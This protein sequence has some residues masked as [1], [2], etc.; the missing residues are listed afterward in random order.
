M[1]AECRVPTPSLLLSHTI[2]MLHPT[3][4]TTTHK[5]RTMAQPAPSSGLLQSSSDHGTHYRYRSCLHTP[6]PTGTRTSTPAGAASLSLSDHD[7]MHSNCSSSSTRSS[8]GSGSRTGR[9]VSFTHVDIVELSVELGHHPSCRTGPPLQLGRSVA[10]ERQRVPFQEFEQE[11][12]PHRRSL[13][14]LY[15]S[16]EDRKK[17]L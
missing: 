15:L 9:K 3:T 7:T 11:R 2:I 4:I 6:S 17:L 8:S 13:P 5:A 12:S 14:Q 16:S 10:Q 1:R